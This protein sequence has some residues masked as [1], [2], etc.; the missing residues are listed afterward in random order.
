MQTALAL[1]KSSITSIAAM[2]TIILALTVGA[3][4][5]Y[6]LKSQAASVVTGAGQSAVAGATGQAAPFHDMPDY[7]GPP[8]P[9]HDMPEQP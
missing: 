3:A 8:V 9:L 7:A 5:G 2:V 1:R 4:G 6:W